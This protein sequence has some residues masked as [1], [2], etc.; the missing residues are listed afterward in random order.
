M[1]KNLKV[2]WFGKK[3]PFCGN[4]TYSREITNLL[5]ARGYDV[6]FFHF[7]DENHEENL[8]AD[9]KDVV[10][11][12]IYKS[13]SYTIPSMKS[14]K[15]VTDALREIKPDIVHASLC[16]SPMDFKLPEIC[17]EQN[18]PLVCTF[19]NA[20]DKR[21]TFHGSAAFLVYQLYA[22][23]LAQYDGVII[24]SELQKSLLEKLGVPGNKIKV[25]PNGIDTDKFT[26]G[27]SEFKK[28]FN[29]KQI[30]TYL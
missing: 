8:L 24:F 16:L 9:E 20:F 7:E 29:G 18:I 28:K 13:Q 27:N 1:A 23:S 14:G 3:S 12:C 10:I 2:A 22:P 30:Y 17:H 5:T 11:P 6:V 4:V 25:I 21:P 26:P 15:I 19:H